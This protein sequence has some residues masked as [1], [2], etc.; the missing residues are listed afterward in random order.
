MAVTSGQM[1]IGTTAQQIDGLS[2]NYTNIM[3]Q[4]DSNTTKLHIG[5]PDVTVNNGLAVGASQIIQLQLGP[6][7]SLWIVSDTTGHPVSWLRW[8]T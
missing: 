7:D 2:T 5:G 4:N 3:V 8:D 1:T 6:L